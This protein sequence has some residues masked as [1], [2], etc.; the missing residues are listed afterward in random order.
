MKEAGKSFYTISE[1][2]KIKGIGEN[3]IL[4]GIAEK[5][6]ETTRIGLRTMIPASFIFEETEQKSLNRA[7]KYFKQLKL[8]FMKIL[9][10]APEYGCC[11]LVVTFHE[12]KIVKK[13]KIYEETRLEDKDNDN[14]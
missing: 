11:G 14:N 1:A 4:C 5:K 13:N 12:G 10:E 9:E 7:E 2:A 3:E 6:I 8:V